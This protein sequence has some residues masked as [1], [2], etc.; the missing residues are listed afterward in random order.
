MMFPL[1]LPKPSVSGEIT[2]MEW[3]ILDYLVVT[4]YSGSSREIECTAF[5]P[6]G[7]PIGGGSG[8]SNGGVARVNI[9]VPKKY[10]GLKLK[11]KCRKR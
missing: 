4:Y 8:Y 1:I 2:D 10:V 11:V 3:N 6:S 9:S 5:S 7:S